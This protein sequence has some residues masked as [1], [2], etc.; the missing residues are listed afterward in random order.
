MRE[1]KYYKRPHMQRIEI[2][3]GPPHARVEA[4]ARVGRPRDGYPPIQPQTHCIYT[5]STWHTLTKTL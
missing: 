3:E 2:E 1:A 5:H 4:C